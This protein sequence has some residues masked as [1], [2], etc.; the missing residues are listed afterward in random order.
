M[1]AAP[2]LLAERAAFSSPP[3]VAPPPGAWRCR[4]GGVSHSALHI[5]AP[6]CRRLCVASCSLK[7]KPPTQRAQ[8]GR[9]P[10][11]GL[12]SGCSSPTL[13][14][15]DPWMGG[16]VGGKAPES[17]PLPPVLPLQRL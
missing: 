5:R 9:A 3:R 2:L 7:T 12:V 13:L 8:G 11:L 10:V 6:A 17:A 4:G 16:L 1:R 14:P 15:F